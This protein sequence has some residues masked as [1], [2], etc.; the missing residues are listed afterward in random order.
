MTYN[1]N[2]FNSPAISGT[3]LSQTG[4][5][6]SFTGVIT[7]TSTSVSISA[8]W[9]GI[10]GNS[11]ILTFTGSNTINTA[12]ATW[13]STHLSDQA[14][15]T[16]GNG[17]Q[18]PTVGTLTLTG[19][20]NSGSAVIGD[21]VNYSNFTPVAAT[22][23][24]ALEAIDIALA[25]IGGGSQKVDKFTLNSTDITNKFVTLSHTPSTAGNTVL[26]V[27]NAASMFYGTDYTVIGNELS[28]SGLGLDGIL[29]INDNL[30]I[31]Y[32]I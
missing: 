29:A 7:G 23:A 17:S 1:P 25:S 24:G 9:S 26:L 27:E 18:I 28:W 8:N 14:T 31:I 19:G 15:L 22:V 16:S 13:N 4:A 30:S 2:T 3:P 12:I 10:A 5:P 32:S 6:A 21:S 11:I 20:I